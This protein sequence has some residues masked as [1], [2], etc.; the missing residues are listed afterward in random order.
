IGI[1]V[2]AQGNRLWHVARLAQ[3]LL[4]TLGQVGLG[5]QTRL[6][7][8]A[9][10]QIPVGVARPGETVDAAMFAAPVGIYRAIEAHV[11]RLITGDDGFRRL[12]AHLG[13][14]RRRHLLLPAVVKGLAMGRR[15]AVVRIDG[16][17]ATAR[18]DFRREHGGLRIL[19]IDTVTELFYTP[20]FFAGPLV[21]SGLGATYLNVLVLRFDAVAQL[22]KVH[23]RQFTRTPEQQHIGGEKAVAGCHDLRHGPRQ[24]LPIHA[25]GGRELLI[26]ALVVLAREKALIPTAYQRMLS[27]RSA[28]LICQ[29]GEPVRPDE[30][31]PVEQRQRLRPVHGY[32]HA[33]ARPAVARAAGNLPQRQ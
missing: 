6:E 27:P 10:G 33:R 14:A 16:G 8:D 31:R 25:A 13:G 19:Y 17:A 15:E 9:R 22:Q 30:T 20:L 4:Q 11:R 28:P 5:D 7:I 26:D 21:V 1:G 32:R 24:R 18:G 12:A 29:R 23:A 2:H 3:L